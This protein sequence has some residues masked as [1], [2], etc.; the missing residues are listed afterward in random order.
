MADH[1]PQNANRRRFLKLAGA[2][3]VAGALPGT[4]AADPVADALDTGTE[5]LQEAL[6]VFEE[7]DDTALLENLDL[8]EGY[9]GFEVLPIAFTRLTGTE[10][11]LVAGLPEVLRVAPN[12]E[13]E[14]ENDDSRADNRSGDVQAGEGVGEYTG[15]NVHAAVIDSGIDGAHADFS[16]NLVAN[17]RWVGDPL[18]DPERTLW[19][20]VGNVNSDDNGHGTHCSGSIGADGTE[21]DGEFRGMAPDVDL[22]A[23]ATGL[24]LLIVK[25][26]AA[27]DHM[28]D[29]QRDGEVDIQIA[30]NSF[31]AGPGEFDPHDPL[32]VAMWHAHEEGMLITFSAG[33]D[34]PENDTLGQR[35]QAPYTLS[36][37]ATHAD[38]SVAD[39]SSRGDV[40]GNHSREEA[41]ANMVELYSGTPEDEID[42]PFALHR[43]GVG[44]KGVDVMSTVNPAHPLAALGDDDEIWYGLLSGTSMSNPTTAGCA[45][46]FLDAYFENHGEFPD[47]LDAINTLEA[48]ADP[49][50]TKELDN[51][52]SEAEY[53]VENM[54]AGYVDALAA[55]ERA[56]DDDLADFGDV[57]LLPSGDG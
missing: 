23:Y 20:D 22:T 47:P 39:F 18:E 25:P 44:A 40:D 52:E 38:G 24:G 8:S 29:R 49:D 41:Y 4:A 21:S 35:K 9:Y 7:N 45:A 33:N 2:A 15:E 3:G 26:I 17:W 14:F 34:G 27:Y 42:G 57:E 48:S 6:V 51:P 32:A 19:E 53:T 37:A 36:V 46:L 12:E 1:T 56:E 31:G 50:A 10:I 5:S 54:G 28:L 11:E 43:N 16:E 30:S 55:V 13:L